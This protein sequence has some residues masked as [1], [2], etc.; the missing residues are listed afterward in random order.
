M[1]N[2]N[3]QDET[4]NESNGSW[5]ET[6]IDEPI[7]EPEE[8]SLT[9]YNIVLCERY[10]NIAHG[11]INGELNNH[12]LTQ[13]RFKEL[14]LDIINNFIMN[15]LCKLEIAECLYLPSYHCVSILKTH[16]LKLV[17]RTWKKIYRTRKVI[18]RVRSHPTILKYREIHGKWSNNCSI[19]P[20]L[21]G[22]LSNLSRTSAITSSRT[23]S[24]TSS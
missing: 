18:I 17:Q 3:S 13:I 22:M 8:P 19:Y 20:G 10:N 21:R 9:K 23:S 15:T 24:R 12:Y 14:N 5:D 7:Y 1:P 2:Y 6:E 4:D 11:F 16:W